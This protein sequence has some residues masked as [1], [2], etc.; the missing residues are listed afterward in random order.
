LDEQAARV[1]PAMTMST[2]G[3]FLIR[4]PPVD[5]HCG[6]CLGRVKNSPC[7]VQRRRIHLQ[8]VADGS[9]LSRGERLKCQHR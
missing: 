5:L 7:S 8:C 6:R 4:S 3:R 1:R 2:T 9:N